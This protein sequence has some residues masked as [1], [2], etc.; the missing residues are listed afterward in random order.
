MVGDY[1]QELNI[2][3]IVQRIKYIRG[4]ESS[5]P[6]ASALVLELHHPNMSML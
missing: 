1:G 6:M 2:G 5:I 4:T 3:G